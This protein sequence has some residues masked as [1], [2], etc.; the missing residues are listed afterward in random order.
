MERLTLAVSGMSC[1]HCVAR[2]TNALK[3]IA[4]VAVEGVTA[5]SA[6]LSYDPRATSPSQI[7]AAVEKAGYIVQPADQAAQRG[8]L[9][10]ELR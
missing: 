3:S 7:A 6:T 9:R 8:E 10:G 4:G 2:V 1:G 5:G